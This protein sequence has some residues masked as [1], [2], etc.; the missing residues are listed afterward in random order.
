MQNSIKTIDLITEI[1]YFYIKKMKKKITLTDEHLLLIQNIC[2]EKFE[3]GELFNTEFILNAIEDIDNSDEKSRKLGLLRD[4]LVRV[5]DKLDNLSD[6]KERYAVGIDQWSLFGG[7][8]VMEDV[9]LILGHYNEYIPGTEESPLGKQYPKELEDHFWE[10]YTYIW[11]NIVD[12]VKILFYFSNRSGL[13]PGTY[14]YDSK[15]AQWSF[16]E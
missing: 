8:F 12:I 15:T 13:H 1:I 16:E 10:L 11:D 14:V 5:K 2:F 3:M 6:N 4:D 7:T 9:A